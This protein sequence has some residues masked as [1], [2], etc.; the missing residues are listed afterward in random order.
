MKVSGDKQVEHGRKHGS[1][2]KYDYTM[3]ARNGMLDVRLLQ[4]LP[5]FSLLP[6]YCLSLPEVSRRVRNR[7]R[8]QGPGFVLDI[9][10]ELTSSMASRLGGGG[11]H[12]LC[13]AREPRR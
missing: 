10:A 13:Y 4:C 8:G 12:G 11:K 3:Q 1:D 2:T 9:A 7:T 5:F 6:Q